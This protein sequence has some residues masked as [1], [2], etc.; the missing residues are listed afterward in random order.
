MTVGAIEASQ[1]PV[2]SFSGSRGSVAAGGGRVNAN[3]RELAKDG[4]L[5]DEQI[6]SFPGAAEQDHA[7]P[8]KSWE[9]PYSSRN[10]ESCVPEVFDKLVV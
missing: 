4:S 5:G 3:V 1:G 7:G 6:V 10:K 8:V 9:D 2:Y